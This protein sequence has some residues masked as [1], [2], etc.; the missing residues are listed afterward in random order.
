M[1]SPMTE[2]APFHIFIPIY[3]KVDLMDVAA[4]AEMFS[5]MGTKTP[6][7]D[8]QV[9]LIAAT[10]DVVT[11]NQGVR[12]TPDATFAEIRR[13]RRQCDLLWAPGGAPDALKAMMKDPEYQRFLIEQSA[14]ARYV[15]SVC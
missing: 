12:I 15:T 11:T 5:W 14:G 7:L 9:Q 6:A 1:E 2:K 10:L 4:P 13:H 8:V 3:K